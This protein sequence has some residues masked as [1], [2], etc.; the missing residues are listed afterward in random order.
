M[1][2]ELTM[3]PEVHPAD[4]EP[5][6]KTRAEVNLRFATARQWA[7]PATQHQQVGTI[8]GPREAG[9]LTQIR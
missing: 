2:K 8:S 1:H 6:Y 7:F 3:P 9:A 4:G 5:W